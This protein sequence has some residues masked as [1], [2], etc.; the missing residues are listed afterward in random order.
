MLK[1]S[2]SRDLRN[3]ISKNISLSS[4]FFVT[5]NPDSKSLNYLI[6]KKIVKVFI[7]VVYKGLFDSIVVY[8]V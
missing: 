3:F 2:L 4:M 1:S 6:T 7:L 5:F 8:S